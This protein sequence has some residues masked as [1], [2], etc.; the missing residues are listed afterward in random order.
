MLEILTQSAHG[1]T[2][3][4]FRDHVRVTG[5]ASDAALQRALDAAVVFVEAAAAVFLRSTTV[6]E[7]FHGIPDRYRLSAGPLVTLDSL[8]EVESGDVI[9]TDDYRLD[10]SGA[11]PKLDA[12]NRGAFSTEI[13]YQAEYS[14]GYSTVPM[15]LTV[16]VHSTA[17][18][19]F[20]NRE[21]A[22]PVQ[23]YAVPLAVH[24]LLAQYGPK[25]M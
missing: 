19:Y 5:T 15:P 24:S 4:D 14:V 20:E 17:A 11:V 8:S 18:L 9:S 2:L 22:T 25:G 16:A 1:F 7:T 21:A 3:G 12:V 13:D 10:K 23:L 6:R